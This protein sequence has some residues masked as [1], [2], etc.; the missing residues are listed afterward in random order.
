[1][2]GRPQLA[3]TCFAFSAV[4]L[5]PQPPI[6]P[7]LIRRPLSEYRKSPGQ[8]WLC[9]IVANALRDIRVIGVFRLILAAVF[10]IFFGR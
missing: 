7:D 5:R 8:R 10:F 2:K 9:L 1:M 6:I 4:A 3:A